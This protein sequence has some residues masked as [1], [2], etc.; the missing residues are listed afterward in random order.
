MAAIISIFISRKQSH[1]QNLKN[2]FLK[3]VFNKILFKV[4][5]HEYAYIYIEEMKFEKKIQKKKKE[6]KICIKWRPKHFSSP[7]QVQKATFH[8]NWYLGNYKIRGQ[9][10]LGPSG[11]LPIY[12]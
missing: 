2:H 4:G 6:K 7:P 5:E 1:D 10:I 3:R 11:P 12:T 8:Q 9:N